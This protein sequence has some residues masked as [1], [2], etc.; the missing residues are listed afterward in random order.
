[1]GGHLSGSKSGQS[2]LQS[3]GL[4]SALE[5]EETLALVQTFLALVCALTLTNPSI[6]MEKRKTVR[7]FMT[8][9]FVSRQGPVN[10]CYK[11]GDSDQAELFWS[12]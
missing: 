12:C 7:C 4:Q 2:F 1:M 11:T 8:N 10:M 6:S 9:V 5:T 3:A